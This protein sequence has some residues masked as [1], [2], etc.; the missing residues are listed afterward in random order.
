[1]MHLKLF[2]EDEDNAKDETLTFRLSSDRKEKFIAHAK[3]YY[4]SSQK[5][6]EF[7]LNT[8]MES[9]AFKRDQMNF[10][11]TIFIPKVKNQ[12]EV[13]KYYGD[14][15]SGGLMVYST[16][17]DV[18]HLGYH[19]DEVLSFRDQI[20]DDYGETFDEDK[21]EDE[22]N[23]F[24]EDS[25]KTY[26]N[27]LEGNYD[28]NSLSDYIILHIIINNYLDEFKDGVY[29]NG[30]EKGYMHDGLNIHVENGIVYYIHT[31]LSI[32]KVYDFGSEVKAYL[33]SNEEAYSMAK[34]CGNMELAKLID[35][36]NDTTSNIQNDLE[37]MIDKRNSLQKK[38]DILNK[39]IDMLDDLKKD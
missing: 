35:E 38:L 28:A 27:F 30:W 33:I 16:D 14:I 23:W 17:Y 21:G 5:C 39:E 1:M 12:K 9:L 22:D 31:I 11:S 15:L 34:G 4:G 37:E 13:E 18:K 20:M 24:I 36:F 29:S 6:L 26:N 2:K 10:N 32:D 25:I 19:S 7:L 8:Y 3:G